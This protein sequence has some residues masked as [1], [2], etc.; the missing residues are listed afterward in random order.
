MRDSEAQ[1]RAETRA[2]Y[3]RCAELR[4]AALPL[5]LTAWCV[6]AVSLVRALID[7]A[8]PEWSEGVRM[9]DRIVLHAERVAR[10]GGF[11]ERASLLS[12]AARALAEGDHERAL[13]MVERADQIAKA[14]E[15]LRE[16]PYVPPTL[17]PRPEPS[18]ER[19][20]RAS[21]EMGGA[22]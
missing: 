16:R 11:V 13:R 19:A 3:I 14:I 21:V 15:T 18:L 22:L 8:Q 20:L 7:G 17:P 10:G 6:A 4:V 12:G 2:H 5:I 9:C 1:A